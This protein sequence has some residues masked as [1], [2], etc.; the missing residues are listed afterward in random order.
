MLDSV[1]LRPSCFGDGIVVA[2]LDLKMHGLHHV[3]VLDV[4]QKI[5]DQIVLADRRIV[6]EYPL[7]SPDRSNDLNDW[8]NLP[9]YVT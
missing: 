3:L 7:G 2:V 9:I 4:G 5:V 6:A 1:S 8:L